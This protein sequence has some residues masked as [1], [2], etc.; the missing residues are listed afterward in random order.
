[1]KSFHVSSGEGIRE[2]ASILDRV[3]QGAEVILEKDQ[4]PVAPPQ[5]AQRPSRLL[6][7]CIAQAEAPCSDV[8]LDEEQR[9]GTDYLL[10][11]LK[12]LVVFL[13]LSNNPE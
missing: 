12:R 10:V 7:E 1:V 8:T 3:E 2:I 11:W 5:P 4:R 13:Q 6:S 9:W